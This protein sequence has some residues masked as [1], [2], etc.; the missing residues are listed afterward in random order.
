[1][2]IL[3]GLLKNFNTKSMPQAHVDSI[4]PLE[5]LSHRNTQGYKDIYKKVQAGCGGSHM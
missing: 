4:T 3:N 1:M 2:I 5:T